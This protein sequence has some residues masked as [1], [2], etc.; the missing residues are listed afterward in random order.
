MQG[1]RFDVFLCH[2]GADDEVVEHLA[3]RLRGQGFQLW[4]DRWALTPG[5]DW[6]HEISRGLRASKACAVVVGAHGLGDWA[7]EELAVAQDRAAKDR[8]FRLF[9][10]LLPG[11]VKPDDPSLDFLANRHWVDLRP[12][13]DDPAGFQALLSA[14][15]GVSHR[16][17]APTAAGDAVCPYRGLEVFEEEHAAF[18][19]GRD[20]DTRRLVEKLTDSR[21]LAVLGPSGC[22]KS[23][24]VRAGVVPALE[25]G[26]LPGSDTWTCGLV[27]P[28]GR[29]LS[30]LAARLAGL[31]GQEA[32]LDVLDRLRADEQTLDLAVSLALGDRPDDERMVLVVDQFEETF[33][34]C[35]DEAERAAF[36]ANLC[37][38][39]TIPGGR[40][41]VVVAMRADFYH[42]C[43]AYPQLA[44]LAARQFL[45]SLLGAD[46][47]REVI[48]R[49][50]W[51]AGL[52]LQP[53]LADT[54]LGDVADRPGSLPLLEYVLLEVW[55]RRRGH[56]LTV[57][58]YV[59]S[60]GVQG[61]LAHRADTTYEGLTAAQQR[62]AR[63]VLLR[64]IQPG[65]GSGDTRRRAEIGE[66]LTRPEEEADLE[67]VVKALADG[68][69][70]T[71]GRDEVSGAR[72]VDVA[73][74]ALIQGWPRLRGWVDEDRELLRTHRRLTEAATEWDQGG[75]E[76]GFLWRGVRL[77]AW[78]DRPTEDLNDLERAFLDA[79][80]QREAGERAARRR[81]VR[82][83]LTGLST[84]L[85]IISVL[86]V[87]VW[88][89]RELAFSRELVA[90]AETQLT[91]DP[92]LS[93]L[94]ARR[95]LEVRPTPEAQAA[96]RQAVME[97][98]VR[99]TL[100]G[101][102]GPVLGVAFSP[103]G[104]R[105]ASAGIDGTVRVW[106]VGGGDPVVLSGHDG[107]VYDVAFGPDGQRVASAGIDGTVRVW[108]V[109]G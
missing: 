84:A 82:L 70:L 62:V 13:I 23:S 10:V 38:A 73:H 102:D 83:A 87:V 105:V 45:V 5:D 14:V 8:G 104:Q 47:M 89:Q 15:S 33:T 42:R 4:L 46:G 17:A 39:A 7:R 68:R 57:E 77:A 56:L 90:S 31:F 74:E 81:R 29:P 24:L 79:S 92:E 71:T 95:A 11:A 1:L 32:T 22:G 30:R 19:F 91:A 76:E 100:R 64:L 85:V 48:E 21:F 53:G 49:P 108:Q 52:E 51:R 55:Q 44:A 101:H 2:H 12:G 37:Y 80:R 54:V 75:R 72:V 109:G 107:L 9:M 86:A 58:A 106:Q 97:S 3:E 93:L 103:D 69:L 65:E 88:F 16:P 59:A 43:A 63:R 50:A 28:G 78:H 27:T 25:Q 40:L 35:A 67:M 6:Q 26:A 98:R 66:L 60:G 18:F 94:L 61:A 96:L 34:L 20:D 99:V 36:V 41:V